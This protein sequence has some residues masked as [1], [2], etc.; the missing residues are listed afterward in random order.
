MFVLDCCIFFCAAVLIQR[1]DEINDW[2]QLIRGFFFFNLI[3]SVE[4][5]N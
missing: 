1:Y 2:I 5:S 3:L 4:N